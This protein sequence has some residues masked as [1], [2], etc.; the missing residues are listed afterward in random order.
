[1]SVVIATDIEVG[2]LLEVGGRFRAVDAVHKIGFRGPN[3][4]L[5]MVLMQLQGWTTVQVPA[6]S[7]LSVRPGQPPL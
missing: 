6:C 4:W 7:R 5:D 1:M 2:D 3:G